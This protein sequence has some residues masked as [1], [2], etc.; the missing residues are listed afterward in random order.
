[1]LRTS[2]CRLCRLIALEM[3]RNGRDV[4][5]FPRHPPSLGLSLSTTTLPTPTASSSDSLPPQSTGGAANLAALEYVS[6]PSS[7]RTTIDD[8]TYGS[9]HSLPSIHDALGESAQP[10][11]GSGDHHSTLTRASIGEAPTFELCPSWREAPPRASHPF[12]PAPSK[13]GYRQP[14][15]HPVSDLP[16]EPDLPHRP[17][18][19]SLNPLHTSLHPADAKTGEPVSAQPAHPTSFYVSPCSKHYGPPSTTSSAHQPPHSSLYPPTTDSNSSSMPTPVQASENRRI[20]STRKLEET[21]SPLGRNHATQAYSESV[22]RHLDSFDVELTLNEV[23][24][25]RSKTDAF[26]LLSS[27][28][29]EHRSRTAPVER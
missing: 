20:D 3:D 23:R 2:D 8:K 27:L 10:L 19:P 26:A 29:N 13:S 22:K 28:S 5:S 15:P 18:P 14:P 6:P 17:D 25:E 1:M 12:L 24:P 4:V 21:T 11:P 7:G 9:Q 16:Q